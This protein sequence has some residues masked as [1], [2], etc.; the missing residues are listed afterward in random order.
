MDQTAR[1]ELQT[2]LQVHKNSY[3]YFYVLMER[4]HMY[5]DILQSPHVPTLSKKINYNHL[6]ASR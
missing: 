5:T 2:T 1:N 6:V 3:K 4:K